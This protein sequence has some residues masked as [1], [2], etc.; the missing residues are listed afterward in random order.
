MTSKLMTINSRI[1]FISPYP[2]SPEILFEIISNLNN[3]QLTNFLIVWKASEELMIYSNSF[4]LDYNVKRMN[5]H[6]NTGL[7]YYYPDKLRDLRKYVME[8][9]VYY[10]Y[11]RVLAISK[12]Y[13]GLDIPFAFTVRKHLNASL[14]FFKS[15]IHSSFSESFKDMERKIGSRFYDMSMNTDFHSMTQDLNLI[16]LNEFDGFCALIPKEMPIP[17]YELIFYPFQKE[18][19]YGLAVTIGIGILVWTLS[20]RVNPNTSVG[21]F[22]FKLY[23]YFLGQGASET[24]YLLSQKFILQLFIFGFLILGTCYQ[25]LL[26]ALISEPRYPYEFKTFE[27]VKAS[28]LTFAADNIFIEYYL[29]VYKQ[30]MPNKVVPFGSVYNKSN[31]VNITEVWNL[32]YGIIFKCSMAEIFLTSNDNYNNDGSKRFY[33]VAEKIVTTMEAYPSSIYSPFEEKLKFIISSVFESGIKHYWKL[34]AAHHP[35]F[36]F[37]ENSLTHS[38]SSKL[39]I[40]LEDLFGVFVLF[41][42]GNLIAII[43]F[44]IEVII[45]HYDNLFSNI[46]LY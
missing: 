30:F 13:F 37:V 33:Q 7:D 18:V 9:S 8:I 41:L 3:I 19:W 17:F 11:P 5:P 39:L 42:I 43:V 31:N 29:M 4:F 23:G 10:Q 2:L 14:L 46:P 6:N 12:G 45:G 15:E 44:I 36:K 28:N 1:M 22:L 35:Y 38:E 21:S 25:S 26:V 32:Q 20:R 27:E 16:P 40:T 34:Q 24:S